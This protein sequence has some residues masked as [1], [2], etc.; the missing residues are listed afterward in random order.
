MLLQVNVTI[1]LYEGQNDQVEVEIL[2]EETQED[3]LVEAD[4]DQ[5]TNPSE[6]EEEGETPILMLTTPMPCSK[7]EEASSEE[8]NPQFSQETEQ[9]QKHAC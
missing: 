1:P 5:P 8:R 3:C 2:Q 6:A 7:E 4:G 9:P